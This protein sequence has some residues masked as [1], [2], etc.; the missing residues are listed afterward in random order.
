[1]AHGK[2][3]V[4]S[5][6]EYITSTDKYG[7]TW[8]GDKNFL[9]LGDDIISQIM[10]ITNKLLNN[11]IQDNLVKPKGSGS[12]RKGTPGLPKDSTN[13]IPSHFKLK[14]VEQFRNVIK[15]ISEQ[16]KKEQA[17]YF[18]ILFRVIFNERSIP[19]NGF[20]KGNRSLSFLLWHEM[21][22]VFPETS[23]ELLDLFPEYG[24]FR[25]I[26][27]IYNH[28]VDDNNIEDMRVIE[29]SVFIYR[30]YLCECYYLLFN[31]E[32]LEDPHD[33]IRSNIEQLH[34]DVFK[35]KKKDFPRISYVGKYIPREGKKFEFI[36]NRVIASIFSEHNFGGFTDKEFKE[37]KKQKTLGFIK[38]TKVTFRKFI[39]CLN[40]INNTV[41]I[42]MSNNRID[43]IDPSTVTSGAMNKYE[44]FFL[45]E[46][47]D[48]DEDT[49]DGSR[50]IDED[51]IDLRHRT[52]KLAK[53]NELNGKALDSVKL[54]NKIWSKV[55]GNKIKTTDR[56][57]NSAQ[58]TSLFNSIKNNI[59]TEYKRK[60][61]IWKENGSIKKD[62]PLDPFNIIV[63]ID[64]SG[65]MDYANVM[66]PAIM[67]GIILTMLSNF[68]KHFI[69][70]SSEPELVKLH[71]R[72]IFDMFI[73][74]KDTNWGTSTDILKANKLIVDL[75]KGY[76]YHNPKFNANITHVI[77]TDG[78]FNSMIQGVS[79]TSSWNTTSE[80]MADMFKKAGLD[81]PNTIYWNMNA[82][83]PGFPIS[84]EMKGMQLA[85]GLSHGMMTS[86]LTNACEFEQL[87][88]NEDTKVANIT[89]SDSFLK[90]ICNPYYNKVTSIV[91]NVK[92]KMFN[93]EEYRDFSISQIKKYQ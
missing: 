74:V 46:D 23:L 68:G 32:L 77:L 76:K 48:D 25:D 30:K 22:K 90:T 80:K 53:D 69:T 5:F 88:E 73:N 62:K 4:I 40:E 64:T 35:L 61:D 15:I 18:D 27:N 66:A 34:K 29:K 72:D 19:R 7:K 1:M 92:E 44:K 81:I 54:A 84:A 70:F 2:S 82:N 49:Y 79:D 93:D 16:P 63:T 12:Y 51:M 13:N 65:S 10:E 56:I 59:E 75:M 6:D 28:Y 3:S 67:I 38:F 83:S 50:T 31:S 9:S 78:Q 47:I 26:D 37:Y 85:E 39:S 89:P 14:I 33:T 21:Y 20:G 45:N 58:F 8:N 52:I 55:N 17:F 43:E 24:C 11:V 36:R 57:I 87:D 41:E 71:G 60:L 86:I 42:K 91:H